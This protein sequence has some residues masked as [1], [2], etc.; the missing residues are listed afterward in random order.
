MLGSGI[1]GEVTPRQAFGQV[2]RALRTERGLSQE[3]LASGSDL[4]RTY[5]SLLERGVNTPTLDAIFALARV[6]GVQP[7]DL[8]ECT[9]AIITPHAHQDD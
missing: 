7:S 6:L 3:K 9:E 4:H 2:L 5:V 8:V 1:E